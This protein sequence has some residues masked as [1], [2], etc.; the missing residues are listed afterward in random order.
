[1]RPGRR[2]G[3]GTGRQSCCGGKEKGGP[4]FCGAVS[5]TRVAALN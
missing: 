3:S 4:P 1:M 5:P 2:A